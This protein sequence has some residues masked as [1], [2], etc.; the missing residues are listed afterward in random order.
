M[1]LESG[2]CLTGSH[3]DPAGGAHEFSNDIFETWYG[4]SILISI[5]LYLG[6]LF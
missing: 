5:P 4:I 2:P 1:E 3:N 6:F